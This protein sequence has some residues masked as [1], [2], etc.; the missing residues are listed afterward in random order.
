MSAMQRS[1]L[2]PRD[3]TGAIIA[4]ALVHAGIVLAVLGASQVRTVDREDEL[5]IDTFDVMEPI[6]PPRVVEEVP[7]ERQEREEGEASP[8]N[9][10]SRATPVVVPPPRVELPRPSPV[11][12]SETPA[13]GTQPTQG[14]GPV[15]GPGTGAGGVGTGTGSGGAGS[16]TGGGGRGGVGTRPSVVPGTT[17]VGRDYPREVLRAWP[18]RGR[19]FV[20][21]RVQLDGRAT[22]CRVDRSSGNPVVDQWTCRLL[23]ERVR[24]RPATD[25]NG[26]PTVSWYGYVQAPVDF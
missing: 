15:P 3:R 25:E 11:I 14:A 8:P 12:A 24:F 19:I 2:T 5:S 10:E 16:G 20:A 22:D 17:L 13:E 9:I 18:R 6:P 23:E 7:D 1:V 26:R 21:V 4:V